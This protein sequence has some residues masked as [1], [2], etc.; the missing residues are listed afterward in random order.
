MDKGISE[1]YSSHAGNSER[2]DFNA[3]EPVA[4][5]P[6][7]GKRICVLG[8]SVADGY[9]SQGWS[10]PEY[11]SRRFSCECAKEAVSGT[12][13]VDTEPL[14][15]VSRLRGLDTQVRYDLFIVQLST[16]DATRGKP[17]GEISRDNDFDTTTV[18]GAIGSIINYVRETWNCPVVFF[19][20]SCYGSEAYGAMVGRLHELQER[21]GIGVIDLWSG[22][23]FNQIPDELRAVY[24]ADDIHPTKAGYRDWWGPEIERQLLLYLDHRNQ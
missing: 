17:L 3:I 7:V 9:A 1:R 11:L 4:D 16:N 23:S 20:G 6:L 13:L 15:Y 8:S 18:T 21:C 5:S 22:E 14:S 2:Y 24:M 19:T 10:V 12:T